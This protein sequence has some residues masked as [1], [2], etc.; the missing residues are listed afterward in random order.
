MGRVHV[1]RPHPREAASPA[2]QTR[3][4]RITNTA[5]DGFVEFDFSIGDPRLFLEMILPV[6]AFDD[7]C[8]TNKVEYLTDEQAALVDKDKDK[9][10][11]GVTAE[12]A[13]DE[14]S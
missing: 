5:R 9:W 8:A 3:Y 2:E 10:H 1:L 11:S 14:P 13:E 4:V 6:A 12:D 7:F